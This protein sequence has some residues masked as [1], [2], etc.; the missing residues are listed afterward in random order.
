MWFRHGIVSV[1][2][3]WMLIRNWILWRAIKTNLWII[4]HIMNE[5]KGH[6]GAKPTGV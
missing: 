1:L 5:F 6:V 4:C 3:I 2:F